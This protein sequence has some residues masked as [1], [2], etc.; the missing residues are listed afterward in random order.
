MNLREQ[1]EFMR[2]L[3]DEYDSQA[4]T[5]TATAGIPF[6]DRARDCREVYESLVALDN[7]CRQTKHLQ[8][9]GAD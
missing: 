9:A 1:M 8:S 3:A 4:K 7:V 5:L 2:K 6:R